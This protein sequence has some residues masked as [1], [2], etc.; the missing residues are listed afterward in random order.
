MT[1][2]MVF[3][4][5]RSDATSFYRGMGPLGRLRQQRSDLNI[6][7]VDRVDWSLLRMV[8][9][10][11][12]QRPYD[13]AHLQMVQLAQDM[14][15]PI[16]VDYDDDLFN[17]PTDNPSFALY[18]NEAVQKNIAQICAMA[19]IVSVSTQDLAV[20]L[21]P[22]NKDIR[23]VPNAYDDVL[24]D[25]REIAPTKQPRL[26][27]WRGSPTHQRDLS[28]YA[29]AIVEASRK[30]PA[31]TWNFIGCD[32]WYLTEMMDE[33]K[34]VVTPALGITEYFRYIQRLQARVQI[35]PLYD[36]TFNRSKSNIAWIE[37]S[38]AGSACLVPDWDEWKQPGATGYGN[39]QQFYEALDRLL[40]GVDDIAELAKTSW[41]HIERELPLS[42]IN[43][44]RS[45][46]VDDLVLNAGYRGPLFGEA[47]RASPPIER[48]AD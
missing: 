14:K 42:R 18:S 36:N 1:N 26:V 29:E 20:K 16:W 9:A 3:C 28:F 40:R 10:V 13:A 6:S 7:I 27:T 2:L 43:K 38:F 22:L 21:R 34:T 32:P 35:V 47:R 45:D 46:I 5:S 37:G 15:L 39:P 48:E 41:A 23:V 30:H 8:D 33:K 24:L 25:Y 17:L 12:L 31:W 11:F 19:N 4:P 44:L